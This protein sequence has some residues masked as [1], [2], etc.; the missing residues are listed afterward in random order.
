VQLLADGV[1][2]SEIARRF[3]RSPE[4]IE[5][6]ET[7]AHL[8]QRAASGPAAHRRLRPIERTVLRWRERGATSADIGARLRRGS[9]Y[10]QQVERL[11]HHKLAR[12]DD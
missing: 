11:A 6:I 3:K 1:E 5:R 2:H 12:V 4:M 8:H 7:M 9:A 10:V